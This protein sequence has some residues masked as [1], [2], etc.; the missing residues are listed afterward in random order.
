VAGRDGAAPQWVLYVVNGRCIHRLDRR[1]QPVAQAP[2]PVAE[3]YNSFVVLDNGL[4][5]TK[6]LSQTTV[7]HIRVLDTQTL[8][9]V[10]PDVLLLE[11]SVARLSALGN[12][13][14][15]VEWA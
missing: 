9:A 5:V 3:P 6:N 15:A 7:A 8:Q 1:C 4:I 10:A 13:V 2:L 14:C 12:T 11:P